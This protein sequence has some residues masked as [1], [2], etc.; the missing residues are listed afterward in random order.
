MPGEPVSRFNA[1]VAADPQ[2]L[3]TLLDRAAHAV[4]MLAISE[5]F[6]R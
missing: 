2:A 1:G 3:R 4:T 5:R 6:L